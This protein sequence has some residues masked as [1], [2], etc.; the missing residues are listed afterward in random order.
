MKLETYASAVHIRILTH[1]KLFHR[2][3]VLLLL[4][5]VGYFTSDKKLLNDALLWYCSFSIC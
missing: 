1:F 2:I 3:I 4:H 5:I